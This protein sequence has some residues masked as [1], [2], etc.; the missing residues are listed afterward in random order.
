VVTLGNTI[1]ASTVLSNFNG[2]FTSDGYNL[3]TDGAGGFLN[4]PA[5]QINAD[6]KLA[7][8]SDNGGLTKTH[9]L[10]PGSAAT[11]KGK[12]NAVPSLPV[13]TD[14]RGIARP[15]DFPGV[16]PPGGG[17]S[18]DIGA[19]ETTDRVQA[20]PIFNVTRLE[21]RDDMFCGTEDCTLREAIL[22]A[23]SHAGND[24][25][26]FA[27]NLTGTIGLTG[28]L[29]NLTSNI[30]LQG[31]GAINLN[32]GRS[33]GGD[34]RIFTISNGTTSGPV[35][36]ISGL[37]I[38]G[39][40]ASGSS[41]PANSGAGIYNDHGT[42]T[43]NYCHFV[44]NDAPGAGLA[45]GAG[46]AIYNNG[47]TSGHATLTVSNDS[48]T[49]NGSGF[50]GGAICNDGTTNGMATATLTNCTLFDNTSNNGGGIANLGAANGHAS[51]FVRSST[52]A[53]NPASSGSAFYLD[54][55][56]S[57]NSG[58]AISNSILQND[59][60][61]ANFSVNNGG[62]VVSQGHNISNDA[63]GGGAGTAP[64]GFLNGAG[65]KRNTDPLLN[66]FPMNDGGATLTLA[67][68]PGSPA[69]N[70]AVNAPTRDQRGFVR[71]GLADI[72]AFEFGGSPAPATDFNL[73]A[74]TDYVLLNTTSRASA[75]WFL[76]GA[77]LAVGVFGPTLPA[78]WQLA[79]TADF[80]HSGGPDYILF[81][82]TTRQT[83]IWFLNTAAFIGATF[84]PTLP[85]G[86]QLVTAVDMDKDSNPDYILFDPAT[87]RTAIWFLSGT[88]FSRSNF[89]P[90]LPGG[91][92]LI[93]AIDFN[94]NG[95]PDYVLFNPP[96]GKTAI[97]FIVGTSLAS[98]AFGPTIPPGFTL[99]GASEFNGNNKP[100]YL[101]FSASSRKTAIWFLNG[102]SF[103]SGTFGPTLAAGFTLAAP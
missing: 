36:T 92:N 16:T 30:T 12:R 98:T 18:S 101:L 48:F 54:A 53:H 11:D 80:D 21:D 8:L 43:V 93:G 100:D 32:V 44:D 50:F 103:S 87:R 59:G 88:A 42:L 76:H 97:W 60:T 78:G 66:S 62:V 61:H 67:L 4:G 46:G 85:S 40:K 34:Y 10:L 29:P 96:T 17:D 35:V 27:S 83:A 20:G 102:T 41:F 71:N 23:N 14:Q 70:N 9:N 95:T 72:G 84:G 1:I 74:M 73:D 77:A 15:F 37:T 22:A 89:G 69:I 57:G 33:T 7:A 68:L 6:P 94:G 75:I 5:D 45:P 2:T 56:T 86:W 51:L 65:D 99:A 79:A 55:T 82:S 19:V 31:P 47:G 13:T 91:W 25:I 28:P 39:G 64:G 63:A 3:A 52:L 38:L 58:L 49:N 24:T 90:T 26:K 81:N